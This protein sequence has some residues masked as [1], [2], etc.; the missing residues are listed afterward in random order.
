MR[1]VLHIDI[2]KVTGDYSNV[3]SAKDLLS[4]DGVE[5]VAPPLGLG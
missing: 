5:S 2:S 4:A 3:L 1:T